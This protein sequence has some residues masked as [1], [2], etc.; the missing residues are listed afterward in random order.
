MEYPDAEVKKLLEKGGMRAEAG[1]VQEFS[2]LMEEV[3]TDLASEADANAKRAGRK[4]ASPEDVI[5][6]KKKIL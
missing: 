4:A 2:R 3:T 6:A 5:I 1:A